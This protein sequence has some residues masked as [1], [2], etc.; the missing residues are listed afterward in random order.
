MFLK[1]K[2]E[3][4]TGRKK[5]HHEKEINNNIPRNKPRLSRGL[6]NCLINLTDVKHVPCKDLSKPLSFYSPPM[7]ICR[8]AAVPSPR[9]ARIHATASS[10]LSQRNLLSAY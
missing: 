2:E 1:E 6:I 5:N 8:G 10:F 9:T 3:G 4:R 7:L